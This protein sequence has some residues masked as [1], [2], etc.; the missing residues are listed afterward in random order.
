[1]ATM[2]PTQPLERRPLYEQVSDRL[3]ELI[4]VQQLQPGDKITPERELAVQLGVSRHSIRQALAALRAI[5]LLEIRHG[6]GVYLARSP[7]DLVPALARELLET[8]ARL[9]HIWEVRQAIETQNARLAARR[10]TDDD[11]RRIAA[12]LDAMEADIAVGGHGAGA[13]REFHEAVAAASHNP[14]IQAL[15]RDLADAF[16][17]TSDT[18]LAKPGQ[19][20]RSLADHRRIQSAI[21]AGDDEAAAAAMLGHLQATTV[22]AF[23]GG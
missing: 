15:M 7:H 16:A 14:L 17:S 22:R 5:G 10:R 4:D 6:D 1:M 19:P 20:G 2:R 23:D 8:Q 9:P 21:T 3:R 13:D 11:L 18:S 12:A